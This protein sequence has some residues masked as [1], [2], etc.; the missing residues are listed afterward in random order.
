MTSSGVLSIISLL[1]S[2]LDCATNC[3]LSI[4]TSRLFSTKDFRSA[5]GLASKVCLFRRSCYWSALSFC[6]SALFFASSSSFFLRYYSSRLICSSLY[7][8][9]SSSFSLRMRYSSAFLIRSYSYRLRR[10]SSSRFSLS[11]SSF[12]RR[13]R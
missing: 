4:A 12:C 10:Y 9:S 2:Y 13:M 5:M 7:F 1:S 6:S 3:G 8:R 11:S